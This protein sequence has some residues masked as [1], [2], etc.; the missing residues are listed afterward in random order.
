MP[1]S[2]LPSAGRRG[3]TTCGRFS[4]TCF[5]AAAWRP[6]ASKKWRTT[7]SSSDGVSPLTELTTRQAVLLL[8][9]LRDR[10]VRLPVYVGM[11]NWHPFLDD[12]LAT[13]ARA[14]VRRAVGFIAAAH[15]SY[16]SCTQ[17]RENVEAARAKLRD[18]GLDGCRD[19]VRRRL[20]L[21]SGVHRSQRRS[22][23]RRADAPAEAVR[24]RARLIFTAHSIPVSMA[25]RFPYQRQLEE[26]AQAVADR[27]SGQHDWAL[28]YQSRSG[29]PEDPWLGPDVCDYLRQ[30]P[31][32]RAARPPCSAPSASSAIT[33][34]CCTTSTPK[35]PACAAISA[36]RWRGRGRQRSS[37][38]CG[39]DG[40][41]GSRDDRTLR[42]PRPLPIVSGGRTSSKDRQVLKF[43]NSKV[44][45]IS[46]VLRVLSAK[47]R[48]R[49]AKAVD[50]RG[51]GALAAGLVLG[52]LTGSAVRPLRSRSSDRRRP[53][54]DRRRRV[55]GRASHARARG[56]PDARSSSRR[57]EPLAALTCAAARPGRAKPICLIPSTRSTRS[58]RLCSPAEARS[59]WRPPTA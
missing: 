24:D 14:G 59:D 16:S 29:R 47:A 34:R 32:G 19:R 52:T 3:E 55:E 36:C 51:R 54:P 46:K 13:M 20:A 10:G 18:A 15:R 25:E 57:P 17:Y 41:C 31:R 8:E 1:S 5:A 50:G 21:A 37:A 4:P 43:Q 48:R 9:A 45:K 56:R 42:R 38:V 27:G 6:N 39:R 53:G 33:S 12:T 44:R 22:R 23:A 7:T 28:V 11:R 35:P 40:R 2:S 30:E 49:H 58:T 26:T